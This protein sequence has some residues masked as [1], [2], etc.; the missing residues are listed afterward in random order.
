MIKSE[1]QRY[2]LFQIIKEEDFQ[3]DRQEILRSLWQSVWRY[4]GMR[5]ANKIGLWLLELDENFGIIR[6]SDKTKEI[7][8]SSL[9]FIKELKGKKLIL[10]PVKTSGTIKALKKVKNLINNRIFVKNEK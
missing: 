5:E 8:I 7:I 2:I 1:R 6:C 10:S 3:I 9:T 4:F